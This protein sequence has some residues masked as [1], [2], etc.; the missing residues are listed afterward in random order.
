MERLEASDVTL[1]GVKCVFMKYSMKFCGQ[2]DQQ[3]CIKCGSREYWC[4]EKHGSAIL[5]LGSQEVLMYGEPTGND[6]SKNF[7][8][9]TAD[10][11]A[12]Q[13][14]VSMAMGAKV[15]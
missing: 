5:S 8:A 11:R 1:N 9:D 14:Q 10:T 6:F 4:Y 7:R 12:V 2:V 13:Q 15:R 3:R